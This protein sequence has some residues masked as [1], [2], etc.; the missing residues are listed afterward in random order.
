[1]STNVQSQ[2]PRPAV[3][4]AAAKTRYDAVQAEL[5]AINATADA[6]KA[7]LWPRPRSLPPCLPG[8]A[9]PSVRPTFSAISNAPVRTPNSAV[10]AWTP[11]TRRRA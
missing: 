6:A 5:A 10:T 11:S 1:M 8:P 4:L 9:R 3:D 2:A 7:P